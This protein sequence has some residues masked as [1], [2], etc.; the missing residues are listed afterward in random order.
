MT[1]HISPESV[2]VGNAV[3]M[4]DNEMR[5][6]QETW[7]GGFYAPLTKKVVTMEASNKHFKRGREC[8]FDTGMIY[9][10][11]M[12]LMN[13]LN[14]DLN[15]IFQHELVSV[16]TSDSMFDDAGQMRITK[17]MVTLKNELKIE[18]S[19]RT[20]PSPDTITNDGCSS[21]SMAHTLIITWTS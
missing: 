15:N 3:A 8:V 19:S 4:G 17:T 16:P 6:F 14:L 9:S 13:S 1:G 10:R 2:N 21:Y 18:Q 20:L 12:D 11:V 5:E 7:P